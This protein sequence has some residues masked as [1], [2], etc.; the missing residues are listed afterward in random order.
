MSAPRPI[1]LTRPLADNVAM[2]AE[3]ERLGIATISAPLL[4]IESTPVSLPTTP[5]SALLITSRYA[6]TALPD[7]WKNVAVYAVGAATAEAVS[8]RGYAH[9]TVGDGELMDLLPR[10]AEEMHRTSLLYLSG[11]DIA[12]D[13][14]G[15]L[16]AKQV[17]VD[18]VIAYRATA[19]TEL[20][21]ELRDALHAGALGGVVFFSKRTA[22]IARLLLASADLTAAAARVDAYCLSL[23][24]AS[25]AAQIPWRKL[26]V[27]HRPTREAMVE[28]LRLHG[29]N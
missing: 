29:A 21:P 24:V 16:A 20:V 22:A 12:L 26:H 5:P 13:V 27:A 8:A 15:L 19:A 2:A 10:I 28:M 25:D 14:V 9:V 17:Q 7:A 18:R 4:H 1:W 6:A 3:L 23:A 11:E